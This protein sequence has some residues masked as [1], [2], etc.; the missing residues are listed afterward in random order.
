MNNNVHALV[1]CFFPEE[2]II[3]KLIVIISNQ[4]NRVLVWDNGGLPDSVRK[5]LLLFKNVC[6]LGNGH[7]IGIG[8]ALNNGFENAIS[9]QAEFVITFDQDSGP[10]SN[11]VETL[12]T[13]WNSLKT[14]G[15]GKV[16]AIGSSFFDIRT[17][18]IQYPF[19]RLIKSGFFVRK[20]YPKVGYDTVKVDFLITSGMLVSVSIWMS[21]LKFDEGLFIDYVDTEWCFRTKALGYQHYGCFN[22]EMSHEVSDSVIFNLFGLSIFRYSPRRRY[23]Y[24]RNTVAFLAKS[25]V[26]LGLKVRLI[27]GIPLRMIFIPFVDNEPM[28]SILYALKGVIDGFRG[29]IGPIDNTEPA[30]KISRWNR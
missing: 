10:S 24:Y 26:P 9:H 25:F 4:V 22:A 1:I 3:D 2:S 23:Y 13:Q 12:V 20:L 11:I 19:H 30:P 16:G 18:F 29:R 6:I 28:L 21:G 7:N 15:G 17:A 8:K 14:D 5:Q 27:L